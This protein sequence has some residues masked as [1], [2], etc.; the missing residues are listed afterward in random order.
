MWANERS[1]KDRYSR[2]YCNERF[3]RFQALLKATFN[4]HRDIQQVFS[5]LIRLGFLNELEWVGAKIKADGSKRGSMLVFPNYLQSIADDI[6]KLLTLP[7][8]PDFTIFIDSLFEK[9]SAGTLAALE[10]LLKSGW[11]EKSKTCNVLIPQPYLIGEDGK[12][13]VLNIRIL[14]PFKK[15][16]FSRKM[17][18]I[19]GDDAVNKIINILSEKHYPDISFGYQESSEGIKTWKI[20]AINSSLSDKDIEII[21]TPWVSAEQIELKNKEPGKYV[22]LII[23]IMGIPELSKIYPKIFNENFNK[24][25]SD[26]I[27]LDFTKE[28]IFEKVINKKPGLYDEIIEELIN[29]GLQIKRKPQIKQKQET[30]KTGDKILLHT[31]GEENPADTTEEENPPPITR[32]EN[33]PEI[34]EAKK[35]DIPSGEIKQAKELEPV[36]V[37]FEC[38]T[39]DPIEITPAHLFISGLTQKSGKTTTLEALLSRSDFSAVTFIT[40]PGE[41]SFGSENRIPPY[42]K[43][44]ANW[45]YIEGIFEYLLDKNITGGMEAILMESCK[46]ARSLK[47]VK[48]KIDEV[49]SEKPSQAHIQLRGYFEKLFE[50]LGKMEFSKNLKLSKG[51]NTLDISGLDETPQS[52]V[53]NAVLDEILK[54]CERTIVLLPE[55][56]KFIPQ[57]KKSPCKYAIMRIVRQGAVK[58]NFVWFDSQDIAGVDKAILKQVSIWFLGYQSE[59]NEVKHVINQIPLPKNQKPKEDHIM[60]LKVGEFFICTTDFVKKVYIMPKGM[61]REKAIQTAKSKTRFNSQAQ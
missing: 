23:T 17:K 11:L 35:S 26:W 33:P 50:T 46:G 5:L 25:S 8:L 4:V 28:K 7:R 52:L 19:K 56:W 44:E 20:H 45:E 29:S 31:I 30:A 57:S 48:F 54:K 24:K 42:F 47:E 58:N 2:E 53:I 40:K 32:E 10:E 51:I 3:S 55:A 39:A 43:D 22:V 38:G 36:L 18:E 34:I 15:Y 13:L 41:K 1:P 59:I 37:G 49:I 9:K 16:F 61:E 12:V 14:E 27:I 6:D 21:I 60:N